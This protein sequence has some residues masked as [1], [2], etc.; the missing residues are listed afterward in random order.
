MSTVIVEENEEYVVGE[1]TAYEPVIEGDLIVDGV[2]TAVS[3]EQERTAEKETVLRLLEYWDNDAVVIREEELPWYVLR[4]LGGQL[5]RLDDDIQNV[6][7]QRFIET[8]TDRHLEKIGEEVGVKRRTNEPDSSYRT[9]VKAGYARA[10]SNATY[11]TFARVVLNVLD[12][13]KSLIS[14]RVADSRPVIVIEAPLDAVEDSPLTQDQII[15][16]LSAS[17]PSAHGV[18]IQSTGTF[19][20]GAEG[21]PTPGEGL[22][23]GT[24]GALISE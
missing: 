20:L 11:D 14:V 8:A 21:E 17:I 5:E 23:E 4:V 3:D 2:F 13:P 24:L 15:E 16:E 19:K 7:E 1:D 22:G 12:I 9:R 6:Y 10:T 18:E